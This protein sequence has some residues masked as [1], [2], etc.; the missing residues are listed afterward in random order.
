[1]K[2]S[3]WIEALA[4]YNQALQLS[5]NS[6]DAYNALGWAYNDMG[7]HGEAFAPLVKAIQLNPQLADAHYGIAYAYLASD[8]Y[9]RALV[10]LRTAV[11]LDP[12]NTEARLSLGEACLELGDKKGALEQYAA[13]K[14]L[15]GKLAADLWDE[16]QD[17][18]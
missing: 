16:I 2:S 14:D 5:P 9:A 18:P 10:F 4:A 17:T 15:D 1:M 12:H 6:A 11:R 3:K 8:N 7:R 13:L